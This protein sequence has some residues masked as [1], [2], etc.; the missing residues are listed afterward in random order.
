[1][2]RILLVEDN[3]G[4]VLLVQESLKEHG[5]THE[6]HVVTDGAAAIRFLA[7]AGAPG[8]APLP[9]LLLLDLNLPRVDGPQVLHEVR[10]HSLLAKMPVI[11]VTSSDAPSDRARV[12]ALGISHYFQKPCDYDGFMKL[13]E[14]VR[15]VMADPRQNGQA[16]VTNS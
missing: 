16:V 7:A 8:A 15:E 10:E 11:V 14:V 9:D 1:M 13:G 6:L 3:R 4:D 5:I 2:F 12:N